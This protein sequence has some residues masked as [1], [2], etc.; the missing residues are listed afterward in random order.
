VDARHEPEDRER[1]AG[2]GIQVALGAEDLEA[3]RQNVGEAR[4]AYQSAL[5][6]AADRAARKRIGNKLRSLK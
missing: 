2:L 4:A 5:K 3:G 1:D 6:L